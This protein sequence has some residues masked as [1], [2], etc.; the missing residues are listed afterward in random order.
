MKKYWLISFMLV[1]AVY[2]SKAQHWTIDYSVHAGVTFP[3]YFLSGISSGVS[4]EASPTVNGQLGGLI[5]F[6]PTKY[7]GFETGVSVVGLGAELEKSEFG[8]RKVSQH[9]YWLQV[10]LSI[11]GRVPFN[12]S[13]HVFLKAGGYFGYGLYGRNYLGG[14][15]DGSADT[16][17]TFGNGGTQQS[18]DYGFTMGVGYQT[19]QGY[20]ISFNYL[21]GIQNIAPVRASYDQRNGAFSLSIGYRF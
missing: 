3:R 17:F 13:S 11:V 7:A 6:F 4:R 1:C 2:S 12:D 9:A 19:K 14:S 8:A 21:A 16:D 10:P 20:T 15:Y 18:T 5:T